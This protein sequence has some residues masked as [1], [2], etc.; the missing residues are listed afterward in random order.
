MYFRTSARPP[1]MFVLQSV[2]QG[3]GAVFQAELKRSAEE[4]KAAAAEKKEADRKQRPRSNI[5]TNRAKVA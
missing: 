5:R 3:G 2:P 1:L 4:A